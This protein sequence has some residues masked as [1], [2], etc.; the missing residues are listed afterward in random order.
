MAAKSPLL[1]LVLAAWPALSTQTARV[2]VTFSRQADGA[3]VTVKNNGGSTLTA[4]AL[5]TGG[6]QAVSYQ[7][8]LYINRPTVPPGGES[9]IVF[10]GPGTPEGD[11]SLEAAIFSNGE[12]EGATGAVEHLVNERRYLLRALNI[13]LDHLP[14]AEQ[15][16]AAYDA[17]RK[18]EVLSAAGDRDVERTITYVNVVIGRLLRDPHSPNVQDSLAKWRDALSAS[19]PS[20]R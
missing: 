4:F 6:A 8:M 12:T 19:K 10:A 20:L 11:V 2:A 14:A 16:T 3:H 7:D 1:V 13:V 18:D 5:R 15:T 9:Q 17:L